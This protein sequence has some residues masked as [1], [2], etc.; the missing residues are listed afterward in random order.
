M[1]TCN[2]CSVPVV[3]VEV[4]AKMTLEEYEAYIEEEE[5]YLDNP[6]DF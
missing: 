4:P 1:E 2:A 5:I 6:F 3:E